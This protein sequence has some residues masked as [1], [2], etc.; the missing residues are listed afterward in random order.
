MKRQVYCV[1]NQTRESFL[2]LSVSVADTVFARLRGLIGRL[3][4]HRDE[5]IWVVPSRGV[6]TIGVLFAIDIIYLDEERRVIHL[7]ENMPRFSIA[8]I[9][10][11]AESVLELPVRTIYHSQTQLGD[12][13]FVGSP[14]EMGRLFSEQINGEVSHDVRA[15]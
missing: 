9:R 7:E 11:H 13:L 3:T 15:V 4:L 8:P 2:S 12:Q 6:H 10:T 14:D 1:Y 5:G